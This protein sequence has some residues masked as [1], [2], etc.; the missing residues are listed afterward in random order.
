MIVAAAQGVA[1]TLVVRTLALAV[2][3]PRVFLDTRHKR[4]E[5]NWAWADMPA[6]QTWS[7]R[8]G[9][10]RACVGGRI[11]WSP[12]LSKW[13]RGEFWRTLSCP[14]TVCRPFLR[15]SLSCHAGRARNQTERLP[16]SAYLWRLRSFTM[17]LMVVLQ[18]NCLVHRR[19]ILYHLVKS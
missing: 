12:F 8:R 2:R 9:M 3:E 19:R 15:W 17:L 10:R 11:K 1:L 18:W 14:F 7:L 13:A 16:V 4:A 6:T 5:T